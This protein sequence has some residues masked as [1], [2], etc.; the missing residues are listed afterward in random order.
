MISNQGE[1]HHE[2][3]FFTCAGEHDTSLAGS[4]FYRTG[5]RPDTASPPTSIAAGGNADRV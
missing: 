4:Y 5:H 1:P 3:D 2:P